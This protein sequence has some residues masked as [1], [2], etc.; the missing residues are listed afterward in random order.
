MQKED[1]DP[2][3]KGY[4]AYGMKKKGGKEVPNCVPVKEEQVEE[5]KSKEG[6]QNVPG[7][8]KK[9]F[10]QGPKDK[11]GQTETQKWAA[12]RKKERKIDEEALD[13]L[14]GKGSLEAINEI[15]NTEGGR[16]KLMD[17]TN[18]ARSEISDKQTPEHKKFNRSIGLHRAA[19]RYVKGKKASKQVDEAIAM[20]PPPPQV[21]PPTITR[22]A[23][24]LH[25]RMNMNRTGAA[26]GRLSGQGGAYTARTQIQRAA[27][28]SGPTARMS[29]QGGTMKTTST[30]VGQRAAPPR[31]PTSSM[32]SGQ[33][34][35]MSAKP[36]VNSGSLNKSEFM[37]RNMSSKMTDGM[38][39][40]SRNMNKSFVPKTVEKVA[41]SVAGSIGKTALKAAGP[42]GAV[43]GTVADA[44]PA[45]AGEDEKARQAK[46]GQKLPNVAPGQGS[47]KNT[48][49]VKGGSIGADVGRTTR[50]K[51]DVPL[52]PSRPDY[53]SKD[54]AFSAA[55]K[56]AGGGEGKF[57]YDNKEYQTNKVGEP[58]KPSSQ[59]KQTSI[60]EELMHTI[61]EQIQEAIEDIFD[62]NLID[63]RERLFYAL[64]EK[65]NMYLDER[66]RQIAENYFAQSEDEVEE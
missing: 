44:T 41:G 20:A 28:Y 56:E 66:K 13:E 35:S 61:N 30:N 54:Q 24:G 4:R 3:W 58:Y 55:R 16:K 49:T 48:E 7:E 63:M 2:C 5:A 19:D 46:Y 57:S 27:P 32:P 62:N 51:A 47:A 8:K 12:Q 39:K 6:Y 9:R 64:T 11:N 42:L 10:F 26:Q 31:A 50:S 37:G 25:Q 14:Y 40:V 45:N 52:P 22:P 36:T 59:L 33:S 43:L 18:K 15:G 65:A 21:S 53:M 23:P 60:K 29:G 38:D 34:G 17:Y 1:K